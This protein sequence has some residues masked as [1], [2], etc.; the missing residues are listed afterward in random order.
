MAGLQVRLRHVDDLFESA[1]GDKSFVHKTWV[2][3][4]A[5]KEESFVGISIRLVDLSE[6]HLLGKSPLSFRSAI[7]Q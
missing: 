2:C 7:L 4:Q 1:L 6:E 3:A 5:N